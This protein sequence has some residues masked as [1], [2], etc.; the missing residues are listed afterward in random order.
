MQ[1]FVAADAFVLFLFLEQK[2]QSLE[3][4]EILPETFSGKEFASE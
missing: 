2:N 4:A 1:G 3:R